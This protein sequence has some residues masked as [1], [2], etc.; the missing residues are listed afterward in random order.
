MSETEP[1]AYF[2]TFTCYGT[3]LHGHQEQSV[4]KYHK[5]YDTPHV[6]KNPKRVIYGKSLMQD[7]QYVLHQRQR[8]I[9]MNQVIETC[10]YRKWNLL[11]LH[12][13][14]NHLH[15]IVK[16]KTAPHII[17]N[18]LKSYASR[19]LNKY[20]SK[21]K[22]RK[23]WSTHGSTRYLWNGAVTEAAIH[24]VLHE[25]GVPMEMYENK[26]RD[27]ADVFT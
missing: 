4:D 15:V 3:R 18:M 8:E 12:V 10:S 1:Y 13:R 24:Y 7:E 23:K 21:N 16:A 9:V 6:V 19:A 5:I 26:S 22:A 27:I 11:A 2:I 25:Q 20:D 17:M 14:S